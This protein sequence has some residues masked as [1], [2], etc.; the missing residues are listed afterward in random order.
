MKKHADRAD[1]RFVIVYQRE[2]HARQMAFDGTLQ[3]KADAER[4]ALAKKALDE[5]NLDVDVWIDDLGDSSRAMFGDLPNWAVVVL[6]D[7]K[8]HAKLEWAEPEKLAKAIPERKVSPSTG[9]APVAVD[10]HFLNAI[11]T[12]TSDWHPKAAIDFPNGKHQ[13]QVMLAHLAT[14]H[15]KHPDRRVWLRALAADGPVRQ[16]AWAKHQLA[17]E[18]RQRATS[19]ALAPR[20]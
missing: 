3:P 14:S 13:R 1:L 20:R 8:I 2:P 17:D 10:Q 15:T 6:P 16:R 7:G 19:N 4:V 11:T 9:K 18:S 5:M 12:G